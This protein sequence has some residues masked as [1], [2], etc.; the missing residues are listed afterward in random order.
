MSISK[1]LML[2]LAASMVALIVVASLSYTQTQRVFKEANYG[3]EMVVPSILT[4]ANGQKHF[5]SL[6]IRV[7]RHVLN[8]DAKAM[9][10]IETTIEESKAGVAAALKAYEALISDDEDRRLLEDEKKAFA[11]YSAALIPTLDMSRQNRSEEALKALT[12]SAETARHLQQAFD[13]HMRYNEK[14]GQKVATDGAA[15]MSSATWTIAI[16]SILAIL[17]VGG[18]SMQIRSSLINRLKQANTIAGS[19]GQGD[20]SDHGQADDI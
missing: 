5:Q 13:A 19:I 15:A 7:Y 17:I 3:N 18:L 20:L 16:V 8:T 12:H 4:I 11:A 10:D 9:A 2:L 6:R 1:R 14:L